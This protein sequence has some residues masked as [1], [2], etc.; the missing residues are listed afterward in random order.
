MCERPPVR[1]TK[2]TERARGGRSARNA[3]T[4]AMPMPKRPM[5]PARNA[6]RR[7]GEAGREQEWNLMAALGTKG[8]ASVVF[9]S[10]KEWSFAGE[11]AFLCRTGLL[12]RLKHNAFA[13][14]TGQETRPTKKPLFRGAKGDTQNNSSI[15]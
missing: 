10:A 3:A 5:A 11:R 8:G 6:S 13:G 9:R 15:G 7:E 4:S 2:M 14:P 1:K 12:T